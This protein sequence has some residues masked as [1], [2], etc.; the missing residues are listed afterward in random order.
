M[1]KKKTA[2]IQHTEK[3]TLT[4]SHEVISTP[5]RQADSVLPSND[6]RHEVCLN[7]DVFAC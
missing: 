5:V 1:G 4:H 3:H 6:G 7:E 2:R